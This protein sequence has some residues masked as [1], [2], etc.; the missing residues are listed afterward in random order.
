MPIPRAGSHKLRD[1]K[2]TPPPTITKSNVSNFKNAT[3]S[4][5]WRFDTILTDAKVEMRYGSIGKLRTE[6]GKAR[7]VRAVMAKAWEVHVHIVHPP[8]SGRIGTDFNFPPIP[9]F[10]RFA[11]RRAKQSLCEVTIHFGDFAATVIVGHVQS[12]S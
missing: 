2:L 12:R 11:Q 1:D 9:Q 3:S 8:T 4:G 10:T 6:V 5:A 7:D